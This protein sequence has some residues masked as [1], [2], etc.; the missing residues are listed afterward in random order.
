[1]AAMSD[2]ASAIVR[3]YDETSNQDGAILLGVP[4]RDL[5]REEWDSYPNWL[6]Q[7]IDYSGFWSIPRGAPK[8]TF[9]T[10]PAAPGATEAG[11]AG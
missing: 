2:S 11:E 7:S 4:M 1:M 3:K 8:D 10:A 5:T 9:R 6:Q